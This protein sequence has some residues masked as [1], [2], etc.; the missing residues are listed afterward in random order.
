MSFFEDNILLNIKREYSGNEKYR[1]FL[2]HLDKVEIALAQERKRNLKLLK[3]NKNLEK[4]NEELKQKLKEKETI[5]VK[6]Y[7]EHEIKLD[8]P[9][10]YVSAKE[11]TKIV[12]KCET[13]EG[14]HRELN[15]RYNQLLNQKTVKNVT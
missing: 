4:E 10:K 5:E 3:K 12:K 7:F 11:Y 13:W 15:I 9:E 2:Q 6:E 8:K 1:L 14:L